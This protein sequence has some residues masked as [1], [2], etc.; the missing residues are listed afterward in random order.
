M[1]IH[2]LGPLRVT[3][4]G[5]PVHLPAKQQRLLAIL[6]MQPNRTV[7]ADRL[8]F[9]LWGD[10][11]APTAIKT[12]QSHVFQLRRLLAEGTGGGETGSAV[13]TDGRGYRL[14]VD[15][16]AI[17][18]TTFE[19]LVRQGQAAADPRHALEPLAKAL[20]L[21]RGPDCADVGDDPVATAEAERLGGLREWAFEEI[22]RIR[23]ALADYEDLIPELRRAVSES[24][25]REQLWADL[26]VA[27][28]RTGRRPE[29]LVAY[30]DAQAAL[31]RELDVD[32][33]HELQE[34]AA[35]IRA[36]DP[37]LIASGR[38]RETAS[39][40]APVVRAAVDPSRVGVASDSEADD[41]LDPSPTGGTD[42]RHGGSGRWWR[43]LARGRRRPVTIVAAV[44]L[45]L[46]VALS[47]ARLLPATTTD[48]STPT[49]ED[50]P[51]PAVVPTFV[52][53]VNDSVGRL[54]GG[55]TVVASV[56]VGTQPDG[57]TLGAGSAWVTS[58]ADN[59]VARLDTSS[60]TV[61]QRIPVGQDPAGIAFGFGAIWVANSGDRTV[62]RIDPTTD[63][64]VDLIPVGTAPTGVAAD[65]RWVWVTNRLD[66]TLTRI[67]PS[68]DT[69]SS[70]SVAATPLGVATAAGSVWVADT[71]SS[72]VVRI[73]RES[74]VVRQTIPVG[75][76]PSAIAASPEGDTVWVVNNGSGTVFRIDT[77]T[78]T[79]TAAQEVGADPTGIAVGAGAVWVAVAA[80]AEIV[81]LDRASGQ[82][83]GR[84]PVGASPRSL[85][86]D[87][88]SP[89]F[90]ARIVEGSH[91]GGT[92]NVVARSGSFPSTPDPTY[93]EWYD[94]QFALL[95]N[96]ALVAYKRVGGPDGL[97]LVPDLATSIPSPTDGGRTWTF[98][99]RTGLTYS[100]GAP[101]RPS[102][103]PG[104]FERAVIAGNASQVGAGLMD[105][106]GIIGSSACGAAPPCDL[107][108][109]IT[110]DDTAGTVT[111]HLAA[112]NPAFPAVIT[113][114]VI[115]P[116]GTPLAESSQPLPATGPYMVARFEAGRAIRLVRN[117]R[118]HE[119]S[120]DAQP[121][122]YP[123][124]IVA[125]VSSLADPTTL[126]E[127]G[128]ADVVVGDDPPSATRLAQLRTRVPAQLHVAPSQRTWFEMMNTTIPPFNDARV[129]RAVN[130]AVDR[131]ALVDIWGGPLSAR[132]ACQAIPPEFGGYQRYCP[133]TV[134]PSASGT[135]LGPDL[136]A[137][138]TLLEQAGVKGQ[139]VTVWGIDDRGVHA[140]VARY[141]T[142]L[143][144][145]LGFRATTHL[146]KVE[147][148]FGG[149]AD[150]AS[151]V[152]MAGLWIK[153]NSRS[154]SE[155]I[156]GIFTC[157]DFPG[158]PYDGQPAGWCDR[159]LD[160]KVSEALALDKTD[161]VEANLLWAEID[162]SVV[163]SGPAVMP[164]NPT[165]VTLVSDRVG[166][167]QHH[168][169]H[170]V[171]L[172][173]LWV[174]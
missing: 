22:V 70:F 164:F 33:S 166:G 24:P 168:P 32:P 73:A 27:L 30:R 149:L 64:V 76:G 143:L 6:A 106:T 67:D 77:A 40:A 172:D 54:D 82:L 89:L 1:E 152:Q 105:A 75:N 138:H 9:A 135:W 74:G 72:A 119:W 39:V 144:N 13:V 103:V 145:R 121:D 51:S 133:Y 48:G 157:P 136:D 92:L 25:Y 159:A 43:I 109:G 35:R 169:V 120:R 150:P 141:F 102:D 174:R 37:T 111:F 128:V 28:V 18:A 36:G 123:D 66:H 80:S 69:T 23:L 4:A 104:S 60:L 68:S 94:R 56:P 148:Y 83:I 113:G 81:K 140:A 160:A 15:P 132:I 29:S 53:V 31:R 16:T 131:Q 118:F 52:T 155:A 88:G 100:N 58:A 142:G 110:P 147:T 90:T 14:A 97:T 65:D 59:T 86:V 154:G 34:L 55:G 95:S 8:I 41:R 101:V 20:A 112:A 3:R 91:R 19:R 151:G 12:L 125:T 62:S 114:A 5:D 46:I 122:G 146:V 87:P 158:Y 126:V 171:M 167:F 50:R 162:A 153:T 79:V 26:M 61:I 156:V 98:Q 107:S 117:P 127:S 130:L 137:A 84:F 47:A 170:Q 11:A 173:Q 124:E 10:D 78:S 38:A 116:A 44:G 21:W 93:V 139:P 49:A 96:D 165:D 134:A 63:D 99:L 17:D 42:L 161:P 2:V 71:D 108:R 7:D 163:D 45:T 85:V 115:V 129:R 57:I